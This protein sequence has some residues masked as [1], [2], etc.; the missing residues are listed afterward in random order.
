MTRSQRWLPKCSLLIAKGP[1]RDHHIAREKTKAKGNL[2]D[3]TPSRKSETAPRSGGDYRI[4]AR[5]DDNVEKFPVPARPEG[6]MDATIP[7]VSR[8]HIKA[9][10]HPR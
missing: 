1:V 5:E 2:R 7:V 4:C 6:L 8:V 3:S 9:R 10:E